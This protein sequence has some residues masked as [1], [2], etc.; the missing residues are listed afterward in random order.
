MEEKSGGK[1]VRELVGLFVA[2]ALCL[3]ILG[4]MLYVPLKLLYD[5]IAPLFGPDPVGH[6]VSVVKGTSLFAAVIAG[7]A[8]LLIA[9]YWLWSK[10]VVFRW[11]VIVLGALLLLGGA[12]N[13]RM[14]HSAG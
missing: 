8:A 7:Y 3:G 6:I 12:L 9:A 13:Q 1:P 14:G 2:I 11:I 5:L 4:A 10:S